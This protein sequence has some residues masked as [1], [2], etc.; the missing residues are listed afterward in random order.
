M[1]KINLKFKLHTLL[2][3]HDKRAVDTLKKNNLLEKYQDYIKDTEESVVNTISLQVNKDDSVDYIKKKL[4]LHLF[5]E[6]K[7]SAGNKTCFYCFNDDTDIIKLDK[8]KKEEVEEDIFTQF[9]FGEDETK[10]E[11]E[12]TEDLDLE[13]DDD[14]FDLDLEDDDDFDLDLEDESEMTGGGKQDEKIMVCH[15]CKKIYLFKKYFSIGDFDTYDD[16]FPLPEL[17]YMWSDNK[18]LGFSLVDSQRRKVE[19]KIKDIDFQSPYTNIDKINRKFLISKKGNKLSQY[20]NLVMDNDI[21]V[22]KFVKNDSFLLYENLDIDTHV[23]D[24]AYM[25]ELALLNL[26]VDNKCYDAY[27]K[28]YFPYMNY[29]NYF[30]KFMKKNM[31]A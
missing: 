25:P 3:N 7:S 10:K 28:L 23:I 20:F 1:D 14:D 24:M 12:E 6:I 19:Y 4:T 26:N 27:S 21:K 11:D 17:F 31:K 16:I 8:L 5:D 2:Y 29:S 18:V 22:N 9:E 30:L 13:L 15:N